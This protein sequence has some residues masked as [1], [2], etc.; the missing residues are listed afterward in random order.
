MAEVRTDGRILDSGRT[1]DGT[2]HPKTRPG[3][4]QSNLRRHETTRSLGKG[5]G[6]SREGPPVPEVADPT[7]KDLRPQHTRHLPRRSTLTR[8]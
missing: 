3:S 7:S 2:G 1:G 6:G 5:P 8:K 4:K